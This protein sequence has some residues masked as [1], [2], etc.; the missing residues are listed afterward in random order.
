[1]A[2]VS[3]V[4]AADEALLGLLERHASGPERSSLREGLASVRATLDGKR[5]LTEVPLAQRWPL[6]ANLIRIDKALDK[7]EKASP[8]ILT[9]EEVRQVKAAR[10]ALTGAV[11][12]A[13]TWVLA[14]VAL[15]L[16]LGTMI[17]W[18]RIVVTVGERIGK[19]HLS[20]AQG[21]AA[22]IVAAGTIGLADF[23]GLPV[24]TTHVLSS[25]VAGTMAASHAGLQ[26]H[27]VRTI[28][29]AWLLTLPVSMALAAMLFALVRPL[30]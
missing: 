28:A 14:S 13:P 2:D 27:T 3:R 7:L 15:S 11:Y 23:G 1:M 5:R 25:G 30:V 12:Y 17:G 24:S 10:V 22:E 6:R 4:L 18:K 20:Y 8:S 16:G 9:V 29:L 21:A 19:T 26:Y